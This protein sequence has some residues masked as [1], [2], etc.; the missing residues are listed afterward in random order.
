MKWSNIFL[1][2][3]SLIIF[4]LGVWLQR[5]RG[6]LLRKKPQEFS[7]IVVGH[8][9]PQYEALKNV[10]KQAK[11]TEASFII[12]TGDLINGEPKSIEERWQNFEKI[13]A[14]S[15]IPFYIAPGNHE[16]GDEAKRKI[17]EE[18]FGE[19]FQSFIFQNSKFILL[20]SNDRT[21]EYHQDIDQEQ[22]EFLRREYQDPGSYEHIFLF[23]HHPLWLK[24]FS[25]T[26]GSYPE[27]RWEQEIHPLIKE[28]TKYVFAGDST[29]FF[30]TEQEGVF[31][32]VDGFGQQQ[33][34]TI[35]YFLE[36]Q[37]KGKEVNIEVKTALSE[38][39]HKIY[40]FKEGER[41]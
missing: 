2:I 27:N 38:A 23:L 8:V 35:P 41:E 13:M 34:K 37:V 20:N 18:R 15:E 3:I 39:Q 29:T 11:K 9:Y 16:V 6:E 40:L 30:Y 7:F 22:R 5:T 14:E 33:R 24:D 12:L 36:V 1:I 28:K 32:L 31:Y 19:T 26:N 4:L 17:F 25:L 21:R 10:L